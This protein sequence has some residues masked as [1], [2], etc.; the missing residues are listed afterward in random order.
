MTQ[1][2]KI[3]CLL[4]PR[5][6]H[7]VLT[8]SETCPCMPFLYPGS[9]PGQAWLIAKVPLYAISVPRIKYGAGLARRLR[10]SFL[11]TIPR[12]IALAFGHIY[13]PVL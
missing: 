4:N 7:V 2:T 6:C 11:R 9:S 12:E 3:V 5:L 8:Y 1:I 10:S 13:V